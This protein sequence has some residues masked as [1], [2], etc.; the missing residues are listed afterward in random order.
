MREKLLFVLCLLSWHS[1]G[2]E[3][4]TQVDV[5][6]LNSAGVFQ[7]TLTS[8]SGRLELCSCSSRSC[9]WNTVNLGGFISL[10]S[11]KN[12]QVACRQLKRNTPGSHLTGLGTPMVHY[13]SLPLRAIAPNSVPIYDFTF[14][15]DGTE[16]NL[17]DC[18]RTPVS[19][20][21]ESHYLDVFMTCSTIV[22]SG[23]V[24][25]TG[26]REDHQGVVEV[27]QS[28][29]NQ[30]ETVCADGVGRREARVICLSLGYENGSI[31][32]TPNSFQGS[33]ISDT[34]GIAT[35][36]C[37]GSDTD[38]SQCIMTQVTAQSTNC[39]IATVA[40]TPSTAATGTVRLSPIST[41]STYQRV[42]MLNAGRWGTICNTSWSIEDGRVVCRSLGVTDSNKVR[43]PTSLRSPESS[44][45]I[46]ASGYMCSGSESRLF[47]CHVSFSYG[48]APNCD[49]SSDA[50]LTCNNTAAA[51]SGGWPP[52][53]ISAVAFSVVSVLLVVIPLVYCLSTDIWKKFRKRNRG[54]A[55]ERLEIELENNRELSEQNRT[56][57]ND[58][59]KNRVPPPTYDE[60]LLLQQLPPSY[61]ESEDTQCQSF[62]AAAVTSIPPAHPNEEPPSYCS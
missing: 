1:N 18:L 2:Q 62:E 45:P 28:S 36:H 13:I 3:P 57:V 6:R 42:E 39:G 21:L 35:I 4:C 23:S 50:T 59:S 37:M 44:R 9:V 40:C 58:E 53:V 56:G 60:S 7:S 54:G 61:E 8:I 24:K 41:S 5:L 34:P 29:T 22:S 46:W 33:E 26:S 32:S 55:N 25:L 11:W 19:I 20:V 31:A 51:P 48:Y 16:S 30:W 52:E 43:V 12:V 47:S 14:D 10:W 17:T 27:Y 15:C 49:H 38:I